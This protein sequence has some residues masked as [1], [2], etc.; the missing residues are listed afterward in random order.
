MKVGGQLSA[1]PYSIAPS[2]DRTSAKRTHDAARRIATVF[3]KSHCLIR[4]SL[5]AGRGKP[6]DRRLNPYGNFAEVSE[7][8][9]K[10]RCEVVTGKDGDLWQS[11]A[12]RRAGARRGGGGGEGGG[13]EFEGGGQG[14]EAGRAGV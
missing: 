12:G 11:W 7:Q 8:E 14:L 3:G 2:E 4:T 1:R 10:P 13:Q 9:G 5:P 6:R